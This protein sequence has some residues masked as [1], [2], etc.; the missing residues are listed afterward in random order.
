MIRE[1]YVSSKNYF[2]STVQVLDKDDPRFKECSLYANN[3]G[4][5]AINITLIKLQD[6]L[7]NMTTWS[8]EQIETLA[9][10]M[11]EEGKTASLAGKSSNTKR[12]STG[13]V[14]GMKSS[15]KKSSFF[16]YDKLG[17]ERG[18]KRFEEYMGK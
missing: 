2:D 14:S 5:V 4:E 8:E 1:D 13:L 17:K 7:L 15:L 9:A 11:V 16:A 10:R 6:S 3:L 12:K 18:Q